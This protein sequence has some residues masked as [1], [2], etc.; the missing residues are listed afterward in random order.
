MYYHELGHLLRA[1]Q[2]NSQVPKW[3]LPD[4]QYLAEEIL[5]DQLAFGMIVL[6]LRHAPKLKAIGFAGIAFAMS[7]VALQEFAEPPIDGKRKIKDATLRMARLLHWGQL[8]ANLHAMTDADLALGE[9]YWSVFRQLL[10]LIDV[11]PA[12]VFLL[13]NQT[14]A[15]P[16]GGW[17]FARNYMVRGCV[18][19]QREKFLAAL[20]RVND[21]AKAQAL[22]EPRAQKALQVMAYV[23]RETAPL[24]PELGLRVGLGQ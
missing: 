7:L 23:L 12:P 14:A 18:F 2:H 8:S 24:E 11:V 10:S 5:A 3:I 15:R 13:L 1:I 21:S 6:E 4:E 19:G 17:T 20:R 22:R 16:E 9:F